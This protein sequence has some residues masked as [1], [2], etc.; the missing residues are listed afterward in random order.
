MEL[1]RLSSPGDRI[2][3]PL[4]EDDGSLQPGDVVGRIG[5]AVWWTGRSRHD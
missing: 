4:D 1:T 3:V 2:L 5:D